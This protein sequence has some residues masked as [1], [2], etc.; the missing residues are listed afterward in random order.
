ATRHL[1]VAGQGPTVQLRP[2]GSGLTLAENDQ[3][4]SNPFAGR[5]SS[6][7]SAIFVRMTEQ[8]VSKPYSGVLDVVAGNGPVHV[9]GASRGLTLSNLDGAVQASTTSGRL[10]GTGL[11][12]LRQASTSSG[13]VSLEGVFTDPADVH[14]SSGS[15]NV[16]LQPDSAVQ[17]NVQTSSGGVSAGN[18]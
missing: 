8:V 16:K 12:H 13:S 7:D 5:S 4:G 17:V 18:V 10:R 6:V 15:V 2:T 14:T 11:G 9:L 1:S 3:S